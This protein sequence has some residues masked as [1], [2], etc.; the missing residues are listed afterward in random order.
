MVVMREA[1]AMLEQIPI[2]FD[3]ARLR[4]EFA[5]GL[6]RTGDRYGAISE[7][8]L[9]HDVFLRIGAAP[10]L[11]RTREAMRHLGIR[12]PT[13]VK[14]GSGIAGLTSR[15]SEI[16]RMVALR[17]SNKEIGAALGI[18]SRTVSTHL[19]N[20]YEKLGVSSRQDV[21]DVVRERE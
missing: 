15:E 3:A 8:R 14:R 11:E 19:S 2:V 12:P 10:E 21:A 9:A 1:I 20:I 16:A 6:A 7:L 4:H 17:K 5:R 18:S 13:R